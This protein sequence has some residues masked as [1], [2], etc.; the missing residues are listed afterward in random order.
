MIQFCQKRLKLFTFLYISEYTC[1][2]LLF[3]SFF[4]FPLENCVWTQAVGSRI[5]KNSKKKKILKIKKTLK[6]IL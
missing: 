4:F 3:G 2:T 5:K 6:K 1:L